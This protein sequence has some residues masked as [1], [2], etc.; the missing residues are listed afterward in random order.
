MIFTG[1]K[2]RIGIQKGAL[3][4]ARVL[5]VAYGPKGRNVVID[6]SSGIL[7]TCDG[8]SI[9]HEVLPQNS[10]ERIGSRILL[11]SCQE[12][13]AAVGDGTTTTAIIAAA[14]VKEAQK[15]IVAGFDPG[16]ICKGIRRG[17]DDLRERGIGSLVENVET[18]LDLYWAAKISSGDDEEVSKVLAEAC[19]MVGRSGHVAVE[20]GRGVGIELDHRPGYE[21]DCGWETSEL[22]GPEEAVRVFDA[23]L[24]A[25]VP[26]YLDSMEDIQSIAEES[27]QFPYP[28]LII[29]KGCSGEARSTLVLNQEKFEQ[30]EVCTVKGARTPREFSPCMQD[31]AA[32]SGATIPTSECGQDYKKW[33]SEWFGSFEQIQIGR[34]STIFEAFET[35]EVEDRLL[36]H[37][38]RLEME[39]SKCEHDYD[40]DQISKRIAHLS[41]GFCVMRVG[42]V[43]E[44]ARKNRRGRVE[45]CLATIQEAL[46]DG[47]VP[48]SGNTYGHLARAMGEC[49]DGSEGVREGWEILRDALF[50]PIRALARNSG[51]TPCIVQRECQKSISGWTGWDAKGL[52]FRD[53]Y[54]SPRVCDP[55]SQVWKVLESAVSVSTMLLTIET[56]ITSKSIPR[57]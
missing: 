32:L 13:V 46:R 52:N 19:M 57:R 16:Q 14:I 2:V 33:D 18:E 40:S 54:A 23:A 44:L 38:Q 11:Q 28:L 1:T 56:A 3:D 29:S 21:I 37:L 31:L 25:L 35:E 24:V 36:S 10:L 34:S 47:V 17:F 12:V 48:G 49:Q 7:M 51:Q 26:E 15:L 42:G 53:L 50:A 43:T 30:I 22:A 9:A 4:L 8:V 5:S 27:S 39:K 20:D 6:R 55:Q 45:D 41:G